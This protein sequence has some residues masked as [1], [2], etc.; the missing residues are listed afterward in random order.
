MRPT[1]TLANASTLVTYPITTWGATTW[2]GSATVTYRFDTNT[3]TSNATMTGGNTW[4]ARDDF[5]RVLPVAP[6]PNLRQLPNRAQYEQHRRERAERRTAA[7]QRATQT[8]LGILDD[9]QQAAYQADRTFEVIGSLGGRYRIR[10]GSTGNVDWIDPDT[11]Q[12][13]GV[14]CAH[15]ILWDGHGHL[16]DPDVALA[17]MLALSTDEAYFVQAANVHRGRRPAHLLTA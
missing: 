15:P 5:T 8:L 13:G 7:V 2:S 17:Q 12:V 1:P 14:L 6:D 3:T 16:P 9:T 10:P 11:S 4:W